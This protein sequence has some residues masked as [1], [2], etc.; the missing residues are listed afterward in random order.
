MR[1]IRTILRLRFE[2]GLSQRQIATSQNIGY[3]YG[4]QLP[5]PRPHRWPVVASA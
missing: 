4:S 2:A 1:K 5:E 3:G